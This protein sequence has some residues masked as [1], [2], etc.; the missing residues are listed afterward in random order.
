MNIVATALAEWRRW[1]NGRLK[2]W[3]AA[4]FDRLVEFRQIGVG[5]NSS[6]AQ[7]CARARTHW[8]AVFISWVMRKAGAGEDFAYANDHGTYIAAAYQNRK[9]NNCSPFKAYRRDEPDA[10]PRPGDL[11][12][13]TYKT[14][15]TDLARVRPGTSGYH[16]DIVVVDDTQPGKLIPLGGNVRNSVS[17]K[18]PLEIDANGLITNR[19]Y[20]AVIKVG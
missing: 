13:T 8:S 19:N 20:F 4:A 14:R 16:C 2:E 7:A 1:D 6:R 9:T 18:R 10:A 17:M 12:C 3:D 11:I 5:Y 15:T